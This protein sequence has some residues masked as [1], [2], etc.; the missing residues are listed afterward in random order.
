M[1]MRYCICKA[2]I[3]CLAV[4][5]IASPVMAE[6]LT[7]S[8]AVEA[9]V[10]NNPAISA[11]RLSAD[12][13]KQ[14]AKG[15]KALVNPEIT[16]APSIVGD[17]GSD[18]ALFF[19]QPLEINGSRRV[20][21][22]IASSEAMA[23]SFNSDVVRRDITLRVTQSYW[24]IAGAQEL[25]KLNEENLAYLDT[26][27]AAVQKQ[28]DV[29]TVPGAQVLKMDVE[30]ARARQELAQARLALSQLRS[31]LNN[32]MGRPADTFF[33]V[34][35]PLVF[36]EGPIERNALLES[37]F[38]SRPEITS[39]RAQLS[40]S[41]GEVKAAKLQRVPDL[42]IQARRE[43][44][45]KDSDSGIAVVIN[46]PLL[47]WGSA[48][49]EKRRAQLAARSQEKQ[50][51]SVRNQVSLDVEQ[52]IQRVNAAAE[53]VREYQ[54]SVLEK[55][56]ELASMARKGYERGANSYLEVLEAQRTLRSVRSSYYSALAEHAKA[57]AQLEWA[58]C[59]NIPRPGN[60]EVKK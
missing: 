50:L 27:Q 33:T 28:Y 41:Q 57:I 21:G 2:V 29:G 22:E 17:A 39:A 1:C 60:P 45:D 19:S 47:D 58:A 26:V 48:G 31:E 6:E 51:E 18:S 40:A 3:V 38:N 16:V 35:E 7:L 9:A 54:G 53:V 8:Q 49:A 10:N 12:A 20:R 43:S 52:A 42:A 30:L 14:S 55:S 44:F 56:D 46:L 36:L 5:L 59:C 11:S 23:E 4:I 15:A 24:D 25:V 37:A 32:L 13:A 34:S